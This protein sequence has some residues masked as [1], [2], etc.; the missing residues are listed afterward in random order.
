MIRNAARS[1]L[2]PKLKTP[3][4]QAM[5]KTKS[6]ALA[7]WMDLFPWWLVIRKEASGLKRRE[8]HDSSA[9]NTLTR[10]PEGGT[11]PRLPSFLIDGR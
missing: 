4:Y 2:R 11:L 1:S 6:Q 3:Q 9:H 7:I 5:K 10:F 8:H